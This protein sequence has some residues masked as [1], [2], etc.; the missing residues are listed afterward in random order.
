MPN[1]AWIASP[2]SARPVLNLRIHHIHLILMYKYHADIQSVV[3]ENLSYN[4]THPNILD[5]KLGTK[6]YDPHA[7][8]EK[9]ERMER[10][11][12][13]TT[14]AETGLRWTGCQVSALISLPIISPGRLS[15]VAHMDVREW[16]VSSARQAAI[17]GSRMCKRC[18]MAA[19][20]VKLPC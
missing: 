12:R 2:R 9:K 4:Y 19:Y 6:L 7:S 18:S 14:S 8:E 20:I 5:A 10:A 15:V 1:P 13:E 16:T 3:L 17:T 11:A